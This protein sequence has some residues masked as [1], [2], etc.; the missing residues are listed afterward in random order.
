MKKFKIPPKTLNLL[1]LIGQLADERGEAAY[2]V[3]GFVRDLFLDS[4]GLD[5]DI[6][7]EG[8]GVGFAK[9]LAE[10]TKSKVE[11]FTH[12]GTSI[13]IIPSFGKVDVATARTE[14]YA[15]PGTLP[16]VVKSVIAQ[17]LFRRDFSI[18]AMALKLAPDFFLQLLDPFNGLQD[19]KKGRIRALHP[20]SFI[21]DPTRVFRA[22]RFEQR[23]QKH[24]EPMTRKWLLDSLKRRSLNTVS[25]ERLRNEFHLI[26]KE[27]HPEKAV[28]R[29]HELGVLPKVHPSLGLS[30]AAKKTL[31]RVAAAIQFFRERKIAIEDEKM[32]W[33]QAMLARST[34]K[35]IRALSKR[36]MLSRHEQKVVFQSADASPSLLKR[37][38]RK[39]LTPSR[40][41]EM[42][43]PLLPEVRCYLVAAASDGLREKMMGYL[44]KIQKLR[45]WIRGRDLQSLGI[46]PGFRYSYILLEA[47]NGQLNGK[48]KN[49]KQAFRWV[50]SSFAP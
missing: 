23:F 6:S 5:I 48:F 10:K 17:D 18:N 31:P 1:K 40:M 44:L 36:L 33:F 20:Q 49:R 19:L 15:K 21:D 30:A 29:L 45:P 3:G 14:S 46:P 2:A 26:F 4:P 37:L 16:S 28:W 8:D 50:Q 22:V 24:I 34:A 11:A 47:L 27:P 39:D 41:Y 38:G 42:L 9:A 32:V 35:Q 43:S 7:I 25:G 12:F 13:V